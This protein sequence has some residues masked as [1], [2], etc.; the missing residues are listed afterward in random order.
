[1]RL[2]LPPLAPAAPPRPAPERLL[3]RFDGRF[4][5]DVPLDKRACATSPGRRLTVGMAG[6]GRCGVA[7][8]EAEA[9][10]LLGPPRPVVLA[11]S[12]ALVREVRSLEADAADGRRAAQS[13][14]QGLRVHNDSFPFDLQFRFQFILQIQ[15]PSIL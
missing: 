5:A 2:R 11:D 12:A 3:V 6:A 15:S 4:L 13:A 1:M 10:G 7:W 14:A 9:G 8:V